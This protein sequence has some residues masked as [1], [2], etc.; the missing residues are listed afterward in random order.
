MR[1][2]RSFRRDVAIVGMA[3]LVVLAGLLHWS[4]SANKPPSTDVVWMNA[5]AAAEPA[6]LASQVSFS[7]AE[8]TPTQP[9]AVVPEQPPVKPME[10]PLTMRTPPPEAPEEEEP[11][12]PPPKP[13]S[14]PHSTATPRPT[15]KPPPKA[16]PKPTPKKTVVAKSSPKP[17]ATPREKKAAPEAKEIATKTEPSDKQPAQGNAAD[18]AGAG[19][20]PATSS[21]NDWYSSV[22]HDRFFGE[23][24]QPKTAL[25]TGAKMS[26][27]VQ[28]R[29]EKDGRV[30]A[31][32]IVRS[33]G[34]VVVDES[35]AA[36]AGRV[37]RVDPP[38]A[39][40]GSGGRYEVKINFELNVEQ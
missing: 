19:S 10:D 39:A 11:A 37:T 29:I 36:V 7:S 27:L 3:H 2:D 28:L 4:A 8:P 5:T 35:V 20:G 12:T 24:V 26:T 6:S 17:S 22:L 14:T 9:P 33:S 21:Q 25:A 23:W 38:P 31:F 34:N 30:S 32:D 13:S 15:P 1:S 40:L 16:T 18:S